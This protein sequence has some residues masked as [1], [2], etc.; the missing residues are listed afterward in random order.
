MRYVRFMGQKE[1]NEYLAGKCLMNTTDW[2]KGSKSN[3]VGFCFFD[4]SE[5]PEERMEYL[6]G[7]VSM[8][9]VAVFEPIEDVRF[10]ESS[11]LYRDPKQDVP[12]SLWEALFAP[13]TMQQV[14]EYSLTQYSRH[15]LRLVAYGKPYL[16][17]DGGHCIE[18]IKR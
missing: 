18:W 8:E 11:G 2:S 10:K 12:E 1:L 9:I 6:T 15:S 14:K 7:V 16:T 13:I 3:S 17:K 4:D 5:A